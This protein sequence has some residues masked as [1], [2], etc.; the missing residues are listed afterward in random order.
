MQANITVKRFI[1]REMISFDGILLP[2]ATFHLPPF[3][4]GRDQFLQIDNDI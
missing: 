4:G 1:N 2:L 3:A